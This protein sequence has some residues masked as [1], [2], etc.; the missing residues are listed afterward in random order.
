[1]GVE[2]YGPELGG[3]E[4][5]VRHI[6]A[7]IRTVPGASRALARLGLGVG[8]LQA[9][10]AAVLGGETVTRTVEGRERYG[11]ILRYPRDLRDDPQAIARDVMIHGA[12]GLTV[13]LGQ[14]TA[15]SLSQGPAAI[16]TEK[17]VLQPHPTPG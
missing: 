13:P 5:L 1:M 2:V 3:I 6:E 12:N 11:V 10:I 17:A 8:D 14:A 15:V 16:R 7:V 4:T 9:T